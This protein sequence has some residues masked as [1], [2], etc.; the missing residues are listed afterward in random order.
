LAEQKELAVTYRKTMGKS[1][2]HLRKQGLIPGNITG[3]NQEPLAVQVEAVA[4]E[5]L[6]RRGGATNV[7][8]LI[9]SDAP[10]QTVLIRRVQHDPTSEKILHIDFSRVSMTERITA[11]IPLHYIGESP[12]V[13]DKG[14]TLLHL[15][16]T[17]D[18][19]CPASAII[20][21]LEVDISQL[22]EI[23]ATLHASDVQ[24]PA[25]Y[26]LI[27]PPGESIVKVA[28]TRGETPKDAAAPAASPANGTPE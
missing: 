27:T 21:Y 23:D 8:R 13:K 10:A 2:K 15:L 18:I 26:T 24:L 17:L 25:Q 5:S 4:F 12:N 11:K 16:E 9:T 1:N 14:G 3:H 19:E 7:I 28:A 6:R 20:D 22:T